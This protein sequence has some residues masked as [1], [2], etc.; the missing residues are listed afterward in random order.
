[1]AATCMPATSPALPC[2]GVLVNRLLAAAAA[3]LH[4]SDRISVR[5]GLLH[6]VMR[7][8]SDI[9]WPAPVLSPA[10]SSTTEKLGES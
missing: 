5:P 6:G 7:N 4:V 3:A 1:M 8:Y 9:Q 2:Q 10:G